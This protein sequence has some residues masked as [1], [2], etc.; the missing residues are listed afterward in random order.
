MAVFFYIEGSMLMNESIKKRYIALVHFLGECLGPNY[1][2]VLQDLEEENS[3]I[4]AIANGKLSGRK[5][6]DPLTNVALRFL[7]G[8][9]YE[10]NDSVMNYIGLLDNGKTVRSSTLFIK[11]N[12]KPVGLLCIN[13]DGSRFQ[14]MSDEIMSMIHPDMFWKGRLIG[15]QT[16]PRGDLERDSLA[17][18][19][20]TSTTDSIDIER[21]HSDAN[22]LMGEMMDEALSSLNIQT[23][24]YTGEDREKIVAYLYSKGLFSIKG[25]IQYAASKLDCS[26]ASIY[27]YLAS[28][29]RDDSK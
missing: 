16:I 13:F 6:G 21:L 17:S 8:R 27:R 5:V 10:K 24:K 18:A 26:Q 15:D 3:G 25:S 11:D 7:A 29:K 2:V 1:E 9:L 23:D 19:P 22:S 4:I 28:V 12:G 14:E 20:S